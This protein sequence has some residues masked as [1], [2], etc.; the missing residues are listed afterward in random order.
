[1]V[2]TFDVFSLVTLFVVW[3]GSA[4]G[5][6]S[7]FAAEFGAVAWLLSLFVRYGHWLLTRI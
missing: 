5:F 7:P 1:M 4:F 3:I 2:G 6:W